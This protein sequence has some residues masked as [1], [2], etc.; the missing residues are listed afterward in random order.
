MRLTLGAEL[1]AILE[2]LMPCV[3]YSCIICPW[4]GPVSVGSH[5]RSTSTIHFPL[6]TADSI[7][8]SESC[9]TPSGPLRKKNLGVFSLVYLSSLR[10][11][12]LPVFSIFYCVMNL[13]SV[14]ISLT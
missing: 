3:R 4:D 14:V 5:V 13:A 12:L 11:S 9:T 1:E 8:C 7:D 10:P 6:D 2:I